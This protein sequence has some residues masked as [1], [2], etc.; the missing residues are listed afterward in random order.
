MEAHAVVRFLLALFLLAAPPASHPI[1]TISAD[2][3][4][5]VRLPPNV[6]RNDEV[7][8]HLTSG[9]TT[10]FLLTINDSGARVEIRYDLW[11]EKFLVTTIDS[12]RRVQKTS[13]DSFEHLVDW[14][15]RT[16][17]RAGKA[18][19]E[20]RAK[21]EVIPFSASEEEDAQR[22][23]AK[24]IGASGNEADPT[25]RNSATGTTGGILDLL[26]GTSVQRHP[27][28]TWRWNLHAEKER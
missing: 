8:K 25:Q 10:V 23:L 26:I 4:L 14:W 17:L 2:G 19:D 27:L 15:S 16:P 24:S 28:Q 1:A 11:D 21:L 6:L 13:I 9:L 3:H 7:R 5:E 22:W 18:R 20:S 12:E